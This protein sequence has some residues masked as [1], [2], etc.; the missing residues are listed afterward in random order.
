M[1]MNPKLIDVVAILKP[2]APDQLI[3]VEPEYESIELPIG[4][5]GTIVEIY[6]HEE[7]YQYLIEFSDDQGNEFAMAL[8]PANDFVVLRYQLNENSKDLVSL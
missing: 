5:V 4:L 2:I 1:A 8:L 6:Q 7:P 3:M